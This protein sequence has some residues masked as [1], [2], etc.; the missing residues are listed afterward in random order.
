[1]LYK[2]SDYEGKK[3]TCQPLTHKFVARPKKAFRLM[4][5]RGFLGLAARASAAA[6]ALPVF[7]VKEPTGLDFTLWNSP[8]V[9]ERGLSFTK[10]G[11]PPA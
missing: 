1:M 9:L 7:D 6:L 10:R 4:T 2:H 5:R 3:E 8:P 11:A